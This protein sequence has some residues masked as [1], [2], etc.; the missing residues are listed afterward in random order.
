MASLTSRMKS[1]ATDNSATSIPTRLRRK[2]FVL[3]EQLIDAIAQDSD[4]PITVIDFGGTAEYWYQVYDVRLNP[5]N[6][7]VTLFNLSFS[8]RSDPWFDYVCGDVT[9]MESMP[10]KSYT[11]GFS[12]S[13]IEHV[14][15]IPQQILAITEMQRVSRFFYL[16]TP[17]FWFPWEPHYNLPLVHW[18][19]LPI[20]LRVLSVANRRQFD[21]EV[22][23]YSLNP[24]SLLS[25]SMLKALFP[26]VQYDLVRERLLVWT[27]S[28]IIRSRQRSRQ[29]A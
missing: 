10:E 24:I 22:R 7:K 20:R 8:N 1:F 14:G 18:L 21:K 3:F 26:P 17:N 15:T 12:N 2:R 16:Q 5:L 29:D 23:A 27:K 9:S 13:L 6:L 25:G 19:A 28:F 4:Q 11:V